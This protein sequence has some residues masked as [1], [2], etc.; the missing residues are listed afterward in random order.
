[1]DV[2]TCNGSYFGKR[3][4]VKLIQKQNV[5]QLII[6]KACS[7][8]H[9][10]ALSFFHLS[11]FLYHKIFILHQQKPFNEYNF[12]TFISFFI[13]FSF[14]SFSQFKIFFCSRFQ[15]TG[16][17]IVVVFFYSY[18]HCFLCY[19]QPVWH[20]LWFFPTDYFHIKISTSKKSS[21]FQHSLRL[22]R[23]FYCAVDYYS[24]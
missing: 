22:R 19:H 23:F 1:M 2:C 3:T 16:S 20:G 10:H 15:N 13:K 18:Y 11:V 24:V 12:S 8:P 9:F 4:Q 14:E 6:G 7:S 17:R 21:R 5:A